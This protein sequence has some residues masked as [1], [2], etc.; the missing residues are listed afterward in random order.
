MPVRHFQSQNEADS[1]ERQEVSEQDAPPSPNGE[2]REDGSGVAEDVYAQ[3]RKDLNDFAH[4]S[5]EI[6][7]GSDT[8][9]LPSV[10]ELKS[11]KQLAKQKV[12]RIQKW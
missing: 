2:K 9:I 4:E 7:L 12:S 10:P 11:R 8:E 3:L 6:P 5:K 1:H